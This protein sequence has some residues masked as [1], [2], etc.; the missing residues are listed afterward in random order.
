MWFFSSCNLL[1]CFY[2]IYIFAYILNSIALCD[3][4]YSHGGNTHKNKEKSFQGGE[5]ERWGNDSFESSD[6]NIG[7]EQLFC[8]RRIKKAFLWSCLERIHI[9]VFLINVK[10]KKKIINRI[11]FLSHFSYIVHSLRLSKGFHF[12]Y[13]FFLLAHFTAHFWCFCFNISCTASNH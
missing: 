1:C 2:V 11:F 7:R 13:N 12:C 3:H 4:S 10:M 5:W 6:W 9:F 8:K